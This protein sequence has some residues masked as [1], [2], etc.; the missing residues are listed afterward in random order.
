MIKGE[1]GN[2]DSVKYNYNN[3]Y[4]II[5]LSIWKEYKNRI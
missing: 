2:V 4:F 5:L 1:G 3:V